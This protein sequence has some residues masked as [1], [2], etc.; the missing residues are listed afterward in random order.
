MVFILF[1]ELLWALRRFWFTWI[2]DTRSFHSS[3]GCSK[4]A[5]SCEEVICGIVFHWAHR[6]SIL[7]KVRNLI[8]LS[9]FI[10][11]LL[12]LMLFWKEDLSR[13]WIW[14][15]IFKTFGKCFLHWI[16]WFIFFDRSSLQ[17]LSPIP[18][19]FQTR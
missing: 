15:F 9:I 11:D 4:G 10:E 7:V 17:W 13:S 3:L 18:F 8:I 14:L 16:W 2:C 1:L 19:F 5:L 6:R 12:N